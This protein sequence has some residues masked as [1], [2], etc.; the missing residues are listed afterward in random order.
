MDKFQ[1]QSGSMHLSAGHEEGDFSIHGIVLFAVILVLS[2]V[3]TFIAAAVLMRVFEWAEKKYIDKPPTPV[4][5]QLREQR[6]EDAMRQGLKPQPDWYDRAVDEKVLEKTF[7]T[8]R[9]Q[10]N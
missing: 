4:Q 7:A 8:P 1:P 6:G 5:Q 9:L 2:G 3:L 10:D